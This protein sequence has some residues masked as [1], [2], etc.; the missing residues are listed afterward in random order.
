MNDRH[1][2]PFGPGMARLPA[3]EP[4]KRRHRRPARWLAGVLLAGL[5]L[6]AF[7]LGSVCLYVWPT[8]RQ[9]DRTGR[10]IVFDQIRAD[11]ENALSVPAVDER[12]RPWVVTL[13][14]RSAGGGGGF[15]TGIVLT[16]DGYILTCAHVVDLSDPVISVETCD[17]SAFDGTVVARDRQTDVAVVHIPALGLESAELGSSGQTLVGETAIAL[18]NPLGPQFSATLTCGILSARERTVTIDRYVMTLL[19]FDASVSPGNSGGPLLNSLGQVIGM[20][21]AKVDDDQVEGIGFAIPIDQAVTVAQDLIRYGYVQQRP[22]LGITVRDRT[23]LSRGPEGVL[24]IDISPDSAA[25]AAG[26]QVGDWII[27]VNG[28]STPTSALLNYEK[29]KCA[30]GDRA[31]LTVLREGQQLTLTCQLGAMPGTEEN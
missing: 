26:L 18:G 5:L 2:D 28:Q 3:P 10:E 4:P 21:N 30:V 23:D 13:Q 9:V 14:V 6:T 7:G 29:D 24:V 20:V 19:Q 12:C 16:A 17:G 31:E 27:A 15:G 11:R 8:G 25:Q 22:W 1:Y